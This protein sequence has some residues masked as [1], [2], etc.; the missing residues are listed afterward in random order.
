[1]KP[2]KA[3][4]YTFGVVF[5]V[6]SENRWLERLRTSIDYYSITVKDAILV[7]DT[8]TGIAGCF[9]YLGTNPTYSA[10]NVYCQAIY[11][12]GDILAVLDP[13]TDDNNFAGQNGGRIKTSG[14]D[15]QFDWGFDLNWMGLPEAAGGIKTNLVLSRL[16]DYKLT[17]TPGQPEIDYA[18]TINYF[19]G[20]ISLGQTLPKWRAVLST[21]W[22]VS[23]FDLM[24]RGRWIDKMDNRA[25]RQYIGETSFTGVGSV[26]YW[27]VSAAWHFMESSEVRIGLNNAFDKQPPTYSPNIQSGTDPAT[28]DIIGRRA[29]VRVEAKF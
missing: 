4:T 28:Y 2:E 29:F 26:A 17:D 21:S 1:L 16:I 13:N 14:V 11:R 23:D 22:A 25:T 10:D 20:G 7:P 19:G 3:D 5:G 24:I 27:D 15:F 12:S 18:G 6:P 9:N 8:N